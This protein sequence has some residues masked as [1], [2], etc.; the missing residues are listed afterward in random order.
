MRCNCPRIPRD[1]LVSG[2]STDN[3]KN[4]HFEVGRIYRLQVPLPSTRPTNADW[5]KDASH[6]RPPGVQ[7]PDTERVSAQS[8]QKGRG[9]NPRHGKSVCSIGAKRRKGG[10]GE[11]GKGR[12]LVCLKAL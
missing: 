8:G 6:I 10:K 12:D 3:K 9:S 1:F 7:T 5:L 11:R 2:S 4:K